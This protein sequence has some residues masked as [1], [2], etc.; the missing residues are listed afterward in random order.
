MSMDLIT[1]VIGIVGII[2]LITA[3]Y[4]NN[5]KKKKVR[6]RKLYNGLNLIGSLLLA[7]YSFTTQTWLFVA[8]NLIW[9]A[10]ALYFVYQITSEESEHGSITDILK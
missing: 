5:F 8:L 2:V 3:F 1:Q 6:R 7:Y 4:L 10:I 9:A